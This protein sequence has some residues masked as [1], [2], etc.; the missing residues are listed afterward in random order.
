M[1]EYWW[2]WSEKS[3]RSRRPSSVLGATS[4]TAVQPQDSRIRMAT[5]AVA[6]RRLPLRPVVAAGGPRRQKDQPGQ[7]WPGAAPVCAHWLPSA[8]TLNQINDT[9]MR[10]LE[11]ND[12]PGPIGQRREE[13]AA[14]V[15][16][17]EPVDVE[18]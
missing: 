11:A 1:T 14:L 4:A 17:G 9:L 7:G 6:R 12:V 8:E 10:L 15:Q 2:S 13:S 5:P 18:G 3:T 16:I